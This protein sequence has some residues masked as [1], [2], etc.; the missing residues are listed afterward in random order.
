MI[1][2]H[3]PGM[4]PKEELQAKARTKLSNFIMD[5][6]GIRGAFL[7]GTHLVREMRVGHELGILETYILGQA[8]MAAALM[9]AGL[10]GNDRIALRI[11]CQGA[12]GGIQVEAN[13]GGEV[14]GFLKNTPIPLETPLESFDTAPFIGAG[15]LT[16][17][18]YPEHA[19]APYSGEVQLRYGRLAMDLANYYRTSEQTPTAFHLSILFAAGGEVAGA[20]ALLLQTLPGLSESRAM[21]LEAT[22]QA[23]P[24]I[25]SA[26]AAGQSAEEYI[27]AHLQRFTPRI[28][29]SKRV[30][31]YCRCEKATLAA[32]IAAMPI[33]SLADMTAGPFPLEV[34]CHNC[35]S[36]Y[37][38]DRAEIED[39]YRRRLH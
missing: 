27:A 19:K 5:D 36:L 13:A 14:R 33:E 16:V 38:F 10:K 4:S 9:A 24:S 31:F 39:I 25:G 12:V 6:G 26:L 37:A 17:I 34:R 15:M 8:Y 23:L 29:D 7:H 22:V 20:G 2:K 32:Y 35:H 18:R 30:E 11:D 21:E 28:L 3:I 1:K